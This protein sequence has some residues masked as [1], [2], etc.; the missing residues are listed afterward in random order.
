MT[1]TSLIIRLIIKFVGYVENCI[2]HVKIFML[3]IVVKFFVGQNVFSF[4][5]KQR[6][7]NEGKIKTF[8]HV[9]ENVKLR[10]NR[11]QTLPSS[12]YRNE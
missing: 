3:F 7:M 9:V 11:H 8:W 6:K 4:V 1:L 2:H 12:L 5:Q 10:G